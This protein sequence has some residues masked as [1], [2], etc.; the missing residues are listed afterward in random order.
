VNFAVHLAVGLVDLDD[1]LADLGGHVF[2]SS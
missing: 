1:Q 2:N